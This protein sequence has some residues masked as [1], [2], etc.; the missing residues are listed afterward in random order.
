MALAALAALAGILFGI[1]ETNN[2]TA[3]AAQSSGRTH[4]GVASCG[5]TTCHG[6]QEADGEI[7]RQDEILQWQEPSTAA[8]SH[9]RA[10]AV[11]TSAR[12]QN[13]ARELGIGDA[14]SAEMCLGCH[15]TYTS[16]RG[17]RFQLTDGVGCES[18]HGPAGGEGGWL[19]S[20]YAVGNSHAANVSRGLTPLDNPRARASVCLDCHFGSTDAGQFVNHRIMA[21]GHPR[22]VFELDLFSTLQQHWDEDDDYRQR[23]GATNHVQLWAVGQATALERSLTLFA[24]PR[25][26]VEGM[27]PEFYFFDCHTCHRRIYDDPNARPTGTANPSRPIPNGYPSY[28][29][30]NMIMLS[31]AARVLAPGAA[32]EFDRNSRAF[33]SAMAQGRSASV[34]AAG[35]L[36]QSAANLASV[37]ANAAFTREQTF[38]IVDTIASEAIRSRF[39]DY[40]G[41][42]QAVMATDT[43]LNAMVSQGTVSEGAAEAIR[44]DINAAYA[45]V[46]EPNAYRP[47]E[48][49]AALGRAASAIR[50]LR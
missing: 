48:F 29:D 46:R 44:T 40:E 43:L 37:F 35:R 6:R 9:S 26:G 49:R 27:F 38:A 11:L 22:I 39:T 5:G 20:H 17:P 24:S 28:Q 41:S 2:A 36:R 31:A 12:S 7:V 47:A 4:V 10:Y 13:I 14:S 16:A 30:E 3:A 33:H 15:A 18:C 19:A 21:A 45:A 42:V 8:G 25:L 34:Q 1:G 50:R 32:G 23:K